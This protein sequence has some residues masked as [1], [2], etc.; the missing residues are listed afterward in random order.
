VKGKAEYFGDGTNAGN[1]TMGD[2]FLTASGVVVLADVK[3]VLD[4][5]AF[6]DRIELIGPNK[7]VLHR[8]AWTKQTGLFKTGDVAESF[9]MDRLRREE[10]K[11]LGWISMIPRPFL[12]GEQRRVT[13]LSRQKWR[14]IRSGCHCQWAA[15]QARHSERRDS[16]ERAL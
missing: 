16:R 2:G 6:R 9:G 15:K 7:V 5:L 4:N 12:S 1:D 8:I 14:E 10:E 11:P 13:T 3:E